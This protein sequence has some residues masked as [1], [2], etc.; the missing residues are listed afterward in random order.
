MEMT[1]RLRPFVARRVPTPVD[2]QDVLQEVLVRIQ[3]GLPNLESDEY[4]SAWLYK[5]A[6]SAIADYWRGQPRCPTACKA[7]TGIE[8]L[9]HEEDDNL[10]EKELANYVAPLIAMLPSPYREA[11]TLTELEGVSQVRAAEMM[12]I[13]VSGMK[14]RVQRAR[15]KLRELFEACCEFDLDASGRVIA[16]SPKVNRLQQC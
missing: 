15:Q 5:V 14:S 7:E 9:A 12:E 11:L 13:S 16:C 10:V 4:L 3:R 2:A 6:R 8:H 1:S